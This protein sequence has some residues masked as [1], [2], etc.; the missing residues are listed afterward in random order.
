MRLSH[1]PFLSTLLVALLW[2]PGVSAQSPEA[3]QLT[4]LARAAV[5]AHNDVLVSGNVD[6]AIQKRPGGEKLR[7]A[8]EA[9]VPVISNR[10]NALT[11]KGLRYSAHRT[12][13]NVKETKVEGASATQRATERVALT[14]EINGGSPVQTEYEQDH[15]F[16][17]TKEGE[18]WRLVSDEIL[19]PPPLPEDIP[20]P[21]DVV[22]LKEAPPG[23]NPDRSRGRSPQAGQTSAAS[24]SGPVLA[25]VTH[26]SRVHSTRDIRLAQ[27]TGYNWQ[28][29]INYAL[30]YWDNY[31]TSYREYSN[32][33]TNFTSQA[34]RAGGWA[35]DTTGD[36]TQPDTWYYGSFTATT[37]YSW[38]GAHNF[39]LF[40]KQSGRGRAATYFSDL[41]EGDLV[42]ADFGPTPDGNISHSMI[43]TALAN[44]APL[45]TYHTNDTKNRP[46]DDIRASNPG[47]NWY[48]LIMYY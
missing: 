20:A 17:Y 13:L 48:G 26:A 36:R 18:E 32:D 9:H 6:Q 7:K 3:D 38:A 25:G 33:C 27:V 30:Q 23:Y 29:A 8:V 21:A 19:L 16:K 34:L 42:Q 35:Y 46:L 31:N 12:T 4:G 39:N 37:S 41:W 2:A 24:M 22:P 44:G 5:E 1:A 45:L 10:R 47:T 11:K 15:L 43:V 40:F 14:L 28:A